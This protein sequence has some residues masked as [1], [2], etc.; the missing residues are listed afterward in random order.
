MP[1]P[2]IRKGWITLFVEAIA[3]ASQR[4]HFTDEELKEIENAFIDQVIDITQAVIEEV[5]KKNEEK[6][7]E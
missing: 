1:E 6:E 7:N 3:N 4:G 2:E 5:T